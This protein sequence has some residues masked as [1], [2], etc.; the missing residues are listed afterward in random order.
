M[1]QSQT[2]T[3]SQV[4]GAG[5]IPGIGNLFRQSNQSL[6]KRELVILLKTTVIQSDQNWSQD[7]LESQERVRKLDPSQQRG[8]GTGSGGAGK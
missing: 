4:P 8:A 3:R 5:S 7:I 2:D 1:S 6:G